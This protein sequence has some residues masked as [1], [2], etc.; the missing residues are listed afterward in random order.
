[1]RL[2]VK[3]INKTLEPRKISVE[4]DEGAIDVLVERGYDPKMGARPMKRIVQKTV[5][6]I[7]AQKI[8]GDEAG[9]GT[10]IRVTK[11]MVL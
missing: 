2:I 10:V 11:E 7:V 6:N 5:E 9:D 3:S 4:L 8:L 1:M